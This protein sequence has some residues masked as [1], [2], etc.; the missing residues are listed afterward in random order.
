MK[1]LII[2]HSEPPAG[3]EEPR[4]GDPLPAAQLN[5]IVSFSHK[6]LKLFA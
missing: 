4:F 6:I 1:V 3:G 5:I 2:F